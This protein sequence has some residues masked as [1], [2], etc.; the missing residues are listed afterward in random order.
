MALGNQK[1]QTML[2]VEKAIW[3][4]VLGVA[5]GQIQTYTVLKTLMETLPWTEVQGCPTIEKNWLGNV[6]N[7]GP[8]STND[9]KV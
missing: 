9:P 4:V 6:L 1:P 7:G 3:Q 5:S 2:A 8:D